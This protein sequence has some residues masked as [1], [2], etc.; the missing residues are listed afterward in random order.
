[1]ALAT[2]ERTDTAYDDL[3]LW[4]S[5]A[6]VDAMATSQREALTAVSLAGPALSEAIAALAAVLAAGGRMAY[7]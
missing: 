7:A 4:S 5:R 2:T 3:D 1:M 6:V